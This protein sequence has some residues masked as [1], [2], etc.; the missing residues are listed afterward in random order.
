[1]TGPGRLKV[2]DVKTGTLKHDLIGHSQANAVTF[3]H[4]GNMLASAGSWESDREQG[5]GVIIWDPRD[6]TK[7]RTITNEANGG[8][9]S[10]AFSPNSKL[11]AICSQQIDKENNSSIGVV[12]AAHVGSGVIE[13]Q[14][15]VAGLAKPVAF[16]PDGKNVIVLC[17]GQQSLRFLDTETG[18]VRHDIPAVVYP[19]FAHWNDFSIATRGS[20][21]AIGG[22]NETRK[23]SVELWDFA[24]LNTAAKNSN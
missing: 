5:T 3:S 17:S 9:S 8:T 22:S 12:S 21:L 15:T 6:G 24:G 19:Q 23:G 13:W 2:W 14:H 16:S 10:V 20:I 1:M 18:A 11:L 7:V 4:D